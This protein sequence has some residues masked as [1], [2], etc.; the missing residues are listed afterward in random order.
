[1][2]ACKT[3]RSGANFILVTNN[4]IPIKLTTND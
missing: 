1:M 3:G 2:K 4:E